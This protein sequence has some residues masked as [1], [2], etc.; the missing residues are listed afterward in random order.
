MFLTKRQKQ[1]LD[2]LAEFIGD[3]GYA[4][5]IEEICEHFGYASLATVHEHLTNLE[6]KGF[7]RRSHN[8]ARSIQL[9]EHP[10]PAMSLP[11]LG[12]VAAGGP[13]EAFEDNETMSVPAEMV[14]SGAD[15]FV[16]RVSG[17]SMIDEHIRDGDH[18]VVSSRRTAEDGEMVVA[19]VRDEG[20]TVKRFYR[21]R[22]DGVRLQPSNRGMSPILRRAG[23]VQ[24]QGVVVG[25][26]R[27]YR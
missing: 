13:I 7:I 19:L 8:Q 4:P 6:R 22:G 2:H 16:L 12:A 20:A 23:E 18:I 17:E 21:E 15:H 14:R 24:V 11:L 25:L 27:S 9:P 3:H 26:I 10:E 1:I 5:S